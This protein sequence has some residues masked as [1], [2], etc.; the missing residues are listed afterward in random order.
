MWWRLTL[1]AT[2]KKTQLNM[3]NANDF[4]LFFIFCV[5]SCN[6]L[7]QTDKWMSMSRLPLHII[8]I[9]SMN[10]VL[11]KR[12]SWVDRV[13]FKHWSFL[14]FSFLF[15]CENGSMWVWFWFWFWIWCTVYEYNTCKILSQ[16]FSGQFGGAGDSGMKM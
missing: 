6:Y 8:I 9:W 3:R 14:F 5:F 7:T 13:W 2:H 16:S 1:K 11:L 4:I 12:L 10:C 15:K